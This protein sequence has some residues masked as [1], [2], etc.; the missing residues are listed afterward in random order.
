[1]EQ[2]ENRVM[3]LEEGFQALEEV[4]ASLN[5][6]DISLE[7]AFASY[8]KGMELLKNCNAQIDL[9]EKKVAILSGEGGSDDVAF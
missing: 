9:V 8:S 4:I 1:M 5:R 2:T 6:D 7:D 3:S